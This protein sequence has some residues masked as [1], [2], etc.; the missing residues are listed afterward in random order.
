MTRPHDGPVRHGGRLRGQLLHLLMTC[1]L[2]RRSR[3]AQRPRRIL[4]WTDRS[5]LNGISC[6]HCH[7]APGC[8]AQRFQLAVFRFVHLPANDRG[9]A[10][11]P[12]RSVASEASALEPAVEHNALS[13]IVLPALQGPLA[14]RNRR[15]GSL[16]ARYGSTR[17]TLQGH[18]LFALWGAVITPRPL[19]AR[20]TFAGSATR[21]PQQGIVFAN[22]LALEFRRTML[23]V[24]SRQEVLPYDGRATQRP[25]ASRSEAAQLRLHE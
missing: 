3:P 9:H 22:D 6:G 1:S 25:E 17:L 14:L 13:L 19:T 18:H 5:P 4:A 2:P 7:P 24:R 12:A 11:I 20:G 10:G 15:T 16:L 21:P 8:G 23:S